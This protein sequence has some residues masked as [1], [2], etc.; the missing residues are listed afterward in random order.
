MKLK[1]II[2]EAAIL[3]GVFMLIVYSSDPILKPDSQRYISKSLMDPPFFSNIIA[4][5]LSLFGTLKSVI[6]LQTLVMGFSIIYFSRTIAVIFDLD[7]LAKAIVSLSLFLPILKFYNYLLPETFGYAFSLLFVSFVIKLIYKFNIYNIFWSS[8]FIILLLLLRDQ[9]LFLYPLVLFIYLGICIINK[10]KK[11]FISL[12]IS[13]LSIVIIS[14]SL[15]SINKY[16][17]PMNFVDQSEI[18]NYG[19]GPFYFMYIDSIYISTKEDLS[20]FDNKNVQNTLAKIFEEMDNR[21]KLVKYYSGRGHF[22]ESF[23]A[24]RDYSEIP[25]RN[26]AYQE[27]ISV[28]DLKKKI[29]IKLISANFKKYVYLIFKKFYDSTWLFI[30]VPFFMTLAALIGFFRYKSELTLL[31]IF[32]SSFSLANHSVIYLFGRI[33]PRYFI[34]SDFLLLILIFILVNVFIQKKKL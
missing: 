2:I 25:L 23:S 13:F 14:N 8:V 5:M 29:S 32:I 26:L 28:H 16:I 19:Y 21:K 27:K 9:F 4:L 22:G 30:F 11:T 24:I 18:K 12:T 7:I 1:K 34:Y 17:N 20:L 10:S 33:Q 31:I 3:F 15:T 6:I